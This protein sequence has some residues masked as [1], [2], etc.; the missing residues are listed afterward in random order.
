MGN[1]KRRKEIQEKWKSFIPR[2]HGATF[3]DQRHLADHV[4]PYYSY[5]ITCNMKIIP[6][7]KIIPNTESFYMKKRICL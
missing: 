3:R 5:V 4:F 6:T 2:A 1:G 7:K